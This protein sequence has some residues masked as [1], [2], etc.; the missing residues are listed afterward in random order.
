MPLYHHHFEP[1]Q[2]QFITSST[3]RRVPV[4]SCSSFCP[5][6]VEALRAARSKF[7][8]RL[9][10]CVLM[11]EHFN[12]LLQP[13]SAGSASDVV[14][15]LKQGSAFTILDRLRRQ[16]DPSSGALLRSF[17]LPTSVHDQAHYRVWQRR[18][19]SFNIYTASKFIESST[20]CTT[21]R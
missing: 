15:Q 2:L 5:L 14:K 21:I 20:T 1:G 13:S 12:V 9:V 10:G 16:P 18:F 6:F 3:Y 7:G 17:R 8:F 4:F 11:P 19:F